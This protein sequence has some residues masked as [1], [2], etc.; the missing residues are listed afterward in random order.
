DFMRFHANIYYTAEA[1][2]L[3]RA[4]HNEIFALLAASPKLT[5]QDRFAEIF[6]K[7]GVSKEDFAKKVNSFG[8]ISKV[9]RGEKRA[10]KNYLIQGT[11]EII[12]NGK[13]RLSARMAGSQAG[14]FDVVSYLIELERSNNN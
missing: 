6:A 9:S 2:N 13:Y 7:Y 12:V 1:F 3:P 11:P 8:I 14:M 5:N 10:R 4:F